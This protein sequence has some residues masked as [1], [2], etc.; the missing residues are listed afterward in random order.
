MKYIMPSN[1]C[2]KLPPI[3]LP[4]VKILPKYQITKNR[5]KEKALIYQGFSYAYYRL[6][7]W[8]R[9]ALPR[10]LRM[11]HWIFNKIQEVDFCCY[12]RIFE[13]YFFDLKLI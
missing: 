5:Q 3:F 1:L 4:R 2:E 10:K 12:Y 11:R 6:R 7:S 8:I 13:V 9:A